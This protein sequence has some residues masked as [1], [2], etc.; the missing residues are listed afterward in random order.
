MNENAKN[1]GAIISLVIYAILTYFWFSANYSDDLIF[2]G[3]TNLVAGWI[4]SYAS[5]TKVFIDL[6]YYSLSVAFMTVLTQI[7]V[8][9]IKIPILKFEKDVAMSSAVIVNIFL[10]FYEFHILEFRIKLIGLAVAM[11]I[12]FM[13]GI[14]IAD[15]IL[16]ILLP[17]LKI[18]DVVDSAEEITN[19]TDNKK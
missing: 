8:S 1:I 12:F 4:N 3:H 5:K 11:I 14:S 9:Q 6:F 7:I 2:I 19:S 10:F 15:K 13:I 17:I 16:G 18:V